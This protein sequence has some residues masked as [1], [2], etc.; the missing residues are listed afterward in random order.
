MRKRGADIAQQVD[1]ADDGFLNLMTDDGGQKDDVKLPDGEVGDKIKKLFDDNKDVSKSSNSFRN[2]VGSGLIS[3]SRCYHS[4]SYG[5]RS[6]Y[7]L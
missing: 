7:G 2:S 3:F 6:R 5:R 4:Q 1:I